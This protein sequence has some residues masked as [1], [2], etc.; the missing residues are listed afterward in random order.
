[1]KEP[2]N[3]KFYLQVYELVRSKADPATSQKV[4]DMVERIL[5]AKSDCLATKSELIQI[6]KFL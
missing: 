5:E 4:V 1:M 3:T 2:I 6:R